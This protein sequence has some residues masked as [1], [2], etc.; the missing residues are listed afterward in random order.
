MISLQKLPSI[1]FYKKAEKQVP[2]QTEDSSFLPPVTSDDFIPPVSRWTIFS[3]LFLVVTVISTLGF[4][5]FSKYKVTVKTNATVRPAGELRLVQPE[6]EGTIKSIH[7]K[8]NQLVKQGDLVAT[9]NS[10]QL[11]IKKNQLQSNIQQTN[12]QLIQIDAQINS[13]ETQILAESKVIERTINSAKADLERN[14]KEYQER[15]TTT[16]NES[17]VAVAT[18]QKSQTDLQKAEADLKFAKHDKLRYKSLVKQGAI[19]QRE[20]EQKRLLFEQAQAAVASEKKSVEIAKARQKSAAATI[21]PSYA[22]VSIAQE[23]IAQEKAKGEATIATLT[24]EKQ[25]LIQSK[26]EINSQLKQTEKELQQTENQLQKNLIR[27]TSDGIILKLNL[28]NPGQV[29]QI[30]DAIAEIAPSNAPLI[31]KANVT[32][33]EIKKVAVNQ[34]VQL[35]V[36]ACP[37]P[38]YGILTGTVKAVSPDAITQQN[39]NT[40]GKTTPGSNTFFEAIIQPENL[41][42]GHK[43]RKCRLQPGMEAKADIISREETLWRFLLK[44]ARLLV[45]I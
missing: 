10:E 27:A 38:D 43:K 25:A 18:L 28:R 32:P 14:Q 19:A 9:L 16:L 5:Y 35:R 21:N 11:Q 44:K 8:N 2:P 34:K 12:L 29:V 3:G 42:F 22:S 40:S 31:I 36:V 23:R 4:A 33:G 15:Q 1:D 17:L 24:K 41:T 45:N 39:N 37:Y 26:A 30:S 7:V 6:V 13:L 20:F